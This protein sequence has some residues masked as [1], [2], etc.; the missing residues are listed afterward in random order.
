MKR[1]VSFCEV[2]DRLNKGGEGRGGE[3]RLHPDPCP[4]VAQRV[5]FRSALRASLREPALSRTELKLQK[6]SYTTHYWEGLPT[7]RKDS[8][9]FLHVSTD[10][11]YGSLGPGEPAF[12]EQNPYAPNNPYAAP[13]AAAGHLVRAY[14]QTYG[15]PTLITNC[16][17]NTDLTSIQRS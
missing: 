11:V 17:N 6:E 16:S 1:P 3:G 12:N 5:R 15:L 7:T 13:K 9:R 10:E 4:S 14:H 2:C 8:F